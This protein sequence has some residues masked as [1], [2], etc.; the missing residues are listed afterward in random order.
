MKKR[1]KYLNELS[2]LREE[3][4]C[5]LEEAREKC[6]KFMEQKGKNIPLQ[7]VKSLS[8]KKCMVGKWRC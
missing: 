5:E 4:K 7:S 8:L 6:N 2:R 3:I 1:I